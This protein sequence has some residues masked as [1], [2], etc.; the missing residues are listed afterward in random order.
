MFVP[1]LIFSNAHKGAVELR[2]VVTVSASAAGVFQIAL[3]SRLQAGKYIITRQ[4]LM[5]R[6]RQIYKLV[7]G[8]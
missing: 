2:G 8:M 1:H 7:F 3:Q 6:L 4:A 5:R